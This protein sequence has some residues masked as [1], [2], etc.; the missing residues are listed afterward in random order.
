MYVYVYSGRWCMH[1]ACSAADCLSAQDPITHNSQLAIPSAML[2]H[3]DRVRCF[4]RRIPQYFWFVLSG[5]MCDVAQALI[6]VC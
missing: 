3:Q 2:E 6:D 5:A 4:G 1:G